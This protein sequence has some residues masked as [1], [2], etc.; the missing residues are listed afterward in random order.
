MFQLYLRRDFYN[1]VFKIKHEI[2]VASGTAFLPNEKFWVR[3]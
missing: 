1:I 2:Y 3:A